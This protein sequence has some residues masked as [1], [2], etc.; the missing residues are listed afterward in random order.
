MVKLH[1]M[2]SKKVERRGETTAQRVNKEKLKGP[3]FKR[4]DKV[5]L[6]TKNLESKQLSHKLDHVRIRLFRIKKQTSNVYYR[7]E[8]LAEAQ[9]HPN[10]YVLLLEPAPKN[11]PVQ[12]E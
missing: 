11:T 1:K 5:Y 9:I 10:F 7:L 2:L 12:I 3:T 6:S 8:L 4:G